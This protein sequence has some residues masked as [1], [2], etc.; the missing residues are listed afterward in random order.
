MQAVLF[1]RGHDLT[2]EHF[3][4]ERVNKRGEVIHVDW[5]TLELASE[6]LMPFDVLIGEIFQHLRTVPLE[7]VACFV[8]RHGGHVDTALAS[9]PEQL[10][11]P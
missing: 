4:A 2:R 7:G 10:E 6:G 1:A 9:V 8:I 3:H 11:P 5:F